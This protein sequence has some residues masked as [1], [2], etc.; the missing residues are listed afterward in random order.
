MQIQENN[1]KVKI[2]IYAYLLIAF[3][4]IIDCLAFFGIQSMVIGYGGR[5]NAAGYGFFNYFFYNCNGWF[6]ATCSFS[7]LSL[8]IV[9]V[10][11]VFLL[12]I[13]YKTVKYSI[14]VLK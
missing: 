4:A 11:S 9:L 12:W 10:L 2:R 6:P 8:F 7:W 13:H 1:L 3:V 5:S 14:K